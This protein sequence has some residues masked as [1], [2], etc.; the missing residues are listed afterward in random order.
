M[1]EDV[2]IIATGV[3][4]EGRGE[5]DL[6]GGDDKVEPGLEAILNG[7]GASGEKELV[8]E[9]AMDASENE[10][11]AGM[12]HACWVGNILEAAGRLV[13]LDR[14]GGTLFR[15]GDFVREL[16]PLVGNAL[17]RGGGARGSGSFVGIGVDAIMFVNPLS[18]ESSSSSSVAL[19][20]IS[21][22]NSRSSEER[23]REFR[24]VEPDDLREKRLRNRETADVG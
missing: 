6:E 5:C 9:D 16:A 14:G 12:M 3:R 19:G 24:G 4:L 8:L 20:T 17:A 18:C 21:E 1:T 2:D 7:A 23:A 11:G 22:R 10:S 15:V 13:E